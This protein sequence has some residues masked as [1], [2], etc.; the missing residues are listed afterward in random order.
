MLFFMPEIILEP[1][2]LSTVILDRAKLQLCKQTGK[3]PAHYLLIPGKN[4]FV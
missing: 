4:S 1:R 2:E 3:M